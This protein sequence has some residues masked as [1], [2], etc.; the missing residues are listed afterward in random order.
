MPTVLQPANWPTPKGYANAVKAN[1]PFIFVAGMVG[2]TPQGEWE[3]DDFV[4]QAKQALQNIVETLACGGAGPEHVVRMTW[5]VKS[6]AEYL[7]NSRALGAVYR[8]VMGREFAA[9][10]LVEV[11][12]L[13]EDRAKLEI[14]VTASLG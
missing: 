5:Y 10:T 7:A 1:G 14:E 8:E 6:K 13:V 9:M 2:W 3:T 12:D 4:G 11:A